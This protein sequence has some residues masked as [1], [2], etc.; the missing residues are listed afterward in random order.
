MTDP[1]D[2]P[3]PDQAPDPPSD[4]SPDPSPPTPAGQLDRAPGERYRAPAAGA[5][6]GRGPG[7][8]PAT[9]TPV[10]GSSA[11]AA[12][13]AE[14]GSRTRG[15]L[16]GVGAAA[17]GALV[18]AVLGQV[19]LGLGLIAVAAFVGWVVAIAIVWGAG[20][21]RPIPRQ[22]LIAALLSA[23]AIVAGLL[24]AWTWSR[25][26]G[27]VLG[28]LDYTDQRYGPVAYLEILVAAAVA[29]LRAR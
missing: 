19:D 14:S 1:T 17:G 11:A 2:G 23:G 20:A 4:P 12:T 7:G 9:G 21:A 6:P 5:P 26:E 13:G 15:V 25:V 10:A 27:G 18:Y 24:L 8:R 22:A 3:T 28:P 16:A 29:G